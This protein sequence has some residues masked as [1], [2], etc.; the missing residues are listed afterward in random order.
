M[1]KTIMLILILLQVLMM[2]SI[3]CAQ[4]SR[5]GVGLNYG[6][7]LPM[8]QFASHEYKRDGVQYGAYALLGSTFSGEG[9][10][11]FY[12]NLGAGINISISYFPIADGYYLEDK[13]AD[14]AAATNF[15][16]KSGPYEVRTYMAGTLYYLPIS[17]KFGIKLKGM[18]GIFWVQTPD[19]L[20][21]ADYF[22]VGRLVW[23]KTP[24]R[25]SSFSFLTGTALNYKLFE[26]VE[27]QLVAEYSYAKAAF[28]FWDATLTNKYTQY[29]EIPIFRLQ[30]GLIITS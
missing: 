21:A 8:G 7:S 28:N 4:N 24:A 11:Y 30:P 13:D 6:Y 25:S 23:A 12:K 26:H 3:L 18:G 1:K 19:Q 2:D 17:E 29:L 5:F 15:R 22:G 9:S 14:D 27:L 16:L 10:W 20:Y